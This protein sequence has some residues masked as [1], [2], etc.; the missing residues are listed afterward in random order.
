MKAASV[1]R[2]VLAIDAGN[3]RVKWGLHDGARWRTRAWVETANVTRLKT[4]FARLPQLEA[5][6]ISNVA[7]D[8]LRRKLSK[9]VPVQPEPVWL[10]ST[11]AQ[12]GIRSSYAK[13]AQLGP[14][15]WASVIGAYRLFGVAAVVVNAG[16]ALTVDALTADGVFAGGV[17]VPGVDLMRTALAE[18]TAGLKRRPGKFSFF[19]DATGD[20]IMS[21][22]INAS[23]GAIERMAGFLEDAGQVSPLCVISGGGATVLAP[24][25]NLE[26]KLVD[27]LVLE[28][29]L[30]I[31]NGAVAKR[32]EK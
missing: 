11:R 26:V 17:I 8:A 20:A 2:M 30:T 32:R 13:P 28:G 25:L 29:L 6:I 10:T 5:V 1:K 27:N 7:G 21:G 9:Q 3:T 23:C 31:A 14:D 15:R 24:H 19:P 18:N 16:T 22:A 12:A 4:A